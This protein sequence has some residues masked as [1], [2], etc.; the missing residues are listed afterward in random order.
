ML[1]IE[2]CR[3]TIGRRSV[4]K[5][6]RRHFRFALC[7]KSVTSARRLFLRRRNFVRT[8]MRNIT[9][10]RCCFPFCAKQMPIKRTSAIFARFTGNRNSRAATA[11]LLLKTVEYEDR[12]SGNTMQVKG[13][14]AIRKGGKDKAVA[15]TEDGLLMRLKDPRKRE[16]IWNAFYCYYTS[17]LFAELWNRWMDEDKRHSMKEEIFLRYNSRASKLRSSFTLAKN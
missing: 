7:T 9:E 13:A 1:C 17:E 6:I 3:A 15:E 16:G 2:I 4:P 12:V 10:Y 5:P 8:S 11:E 14:R